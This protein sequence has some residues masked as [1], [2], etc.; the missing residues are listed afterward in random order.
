MRDAYKVMP[1]ATIWTTFQDQFRHQFISDHIYRKKEEEFETLK[2]NQMTVAV[3]L[4][5]FL[6]LSK[7]A[8]DLVDTEAKKIKR[9]VG[10]LHPMY[11]EHVVMYKRLETFDDAVDRKYTTKEMAIKKR[12]VDPRRTAFQ[13]TKSFQQKRQRGVVNGAPKCGTCGNEHLT[14]RCWRNTRACIVRGSMEH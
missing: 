1:N 9:F 11:E 5:T 4:L 13:S 8:K 14:E 7:F 12:N 2:Q 10:G 3:Y 6:Q